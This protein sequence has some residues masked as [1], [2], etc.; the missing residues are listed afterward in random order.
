MFLILI[1]IYFIINP[2]SSKT[3]SSQNSSFKSSKIYFFSTSSI[4]S[5][6]YSILVYISFN[7]SQ[8]YFTSIEHSIYNFILI[9][10]IPLT[11]VLLPYSQSKIINT[12]EIHSPITKIDIQFIKE[13]FFNINLVYIYFIF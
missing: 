13:I 10:I 9:L 8:L 2:T 3:G 1:C 6:I 4:Y 5:I 11:F 7:L 12:D